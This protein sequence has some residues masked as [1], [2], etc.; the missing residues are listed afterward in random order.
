MLNSEII[1][2]HPPKQPGFTSL[3]FE[4]STDSSQQSEHKY[5]INMVTITKIG[6]R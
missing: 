4:S 6:G 2:L 1:D 3:Q 5:S